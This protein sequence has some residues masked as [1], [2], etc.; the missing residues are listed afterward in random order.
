MTETVALVAA[1]KAGDLAA[2]GEVVR[3]FQAMAYAYAYSILGDWHQA[4]DAVQ[5]A[6]VEAFVCLG[7]L[8]EP[9]V[10]EREGARGRGRDRA[11][12]LRAH[13]GRA[14][15][16]AQGHPRREGAAFTNAMLQAERDFRQCTVPAGHRYKSVTGK[17]N[18]RVSRM[19][20]VGWD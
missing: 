5:D 8:R 15:G 16:A 11:G 7:R 12:R 10:F 20:D 13:A 19:A 1:A 18:K 4:E 6:F 17:R 2:Y 3:R 14:G 9:G